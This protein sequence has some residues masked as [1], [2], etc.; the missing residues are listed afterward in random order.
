MIR[1]LTKQEINAPD[2][3]ILFLEVNGYTFINELTNE[4]LTNFILEVASG[5]HALLSVQDWLMANSIKK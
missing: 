1:Y 5:N 4:A 2:A 3:C